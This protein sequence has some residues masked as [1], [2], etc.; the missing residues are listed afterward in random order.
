MGAQKLYGITVVG[1]NGGS[2]KLSVDECT[3]TN[4]HALVKGL[5]ML[6]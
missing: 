6:L 1:R 3:C 4:V 2:D 5:L